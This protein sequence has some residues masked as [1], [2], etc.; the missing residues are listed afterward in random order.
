MAE[1]HRWHH[2]LK[3]E[4][5]NSNYGNNILFWD[6]VFGTVYY[7]RDRT[8]SADIGLSDMDGFPADYLGQ[9]LSPLRWEALTAPGMEHPSA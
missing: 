8:A 9:V 7:P 6:L 5:A 1:L 3:L 2:S 4:E